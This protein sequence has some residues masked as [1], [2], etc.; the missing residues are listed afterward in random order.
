MT[1]VSL[2]EAKTTGLFTEPGNHGWNDP[3]IKGETYPA[4]ATEIL[5]DILSKTGNTGFLQK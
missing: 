4:T 1:N 5:K 3:K 2:L